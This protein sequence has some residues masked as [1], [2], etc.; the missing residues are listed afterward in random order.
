MGDEGT[1]RGVYIAPVNPASFPGVAAKVEAQSEVLSQMGKCDVV[2]LGTHNTLP[3]KIAR[4]LPFFS[5]GINWDTVNVE[6]CDWIY[7]RRPQF[8]SKG[9]RRFLTRAKKD[10]PNLKVVLELPTYPYDA[11]YGGLA[12]QLVLARDRH[13]RKRLA[14]LVDRVAVLT[15]DDSVF[16][17]P[18]IGVTNGIDLSSQTPRE[19]SR[20]DELNIVVVAVFS[21]SHGVD[22][23]IKGISEYYSQGGDRAI[24]LHLI[25]DS[26]FVAK[27]KQEVARRGLEDRVVFYGQQESPF[28]DAVYDRCTLAV[29]PLGI[30]RIGLSSSAPLKSREYLAKGIPF[31]Y[32]GEIDV[33]VKH[34]ADFCLQLP[35]EDEPVDIESV[36]EFHDHIYDKED[37]RVLIGRIRAF[38]ERYVSMDKAMEPVMEYLI[39][40]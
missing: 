28:I 35:A 22:R 31:I 8:I 7:L 5:D 2:F 15:D 3:L 4:R 26:P 14:C 19:P 37:E 24:R 27:L 25:G 36:I 40:C 9:M 29:A 20:G 17:L 16:G 21:P 30:H 32:S 10:N 23:L 18:A 34:S 33:L 38:A 39:S 11:E 13:H 12:N 1:L 6:S